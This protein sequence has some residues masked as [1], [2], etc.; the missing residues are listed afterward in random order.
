MNITLVDLNHGTIVAIVHIADAFFEEICD[1]HVGEFAFERN[2]YVEDQVCVGRT[3][4]YAKIV[5][6]KTTVQIA[7]DFFNLA[8]YFID[9]LVVCD[10]GINVDGGRT[11][12]FV[13]K[14][15]L[16]VVNL[17]V[18]NQ[19]ISVGGNLSV[20]GKN[21]SAWTVV[22]DNQSCMP[23]TRGWARTDLFDFL[24]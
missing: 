9:L 21:Q 3:F 17:I 5:N 14:L 11:I 23:W 6:G 4:Y 22:M 12:Q 1:L 8:A 18:D 7:S 24:Y 15:M 2:R 20:E 19:Q 10:N 13:L 16:N